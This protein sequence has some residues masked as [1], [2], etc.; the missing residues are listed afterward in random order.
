V[1]DLADLFKRGLREFD[2]RVRLVKEDQWNEST[3]CSEWDVRAL[4]NHIVYEDRWTPPILEGKTIEEVGDQFEGD[5]LGDD[6]VAAWD[7]ASREAAAAVERTSMDKI[8]HLSFGDVPA[9][10]YIDQLLN[11]HVIH[12]WDLARGIAADDSLDP[13]LVDYLYEKAKP[14]E[15]LLKGSGLFGEKIE[16]AEDADPQT[17][18]LAIMGR[19]P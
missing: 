7:E 14:Q 15:E 16:P 5:L 6:P 2:D 17:K 1:T 18:L 8:V 9:Q 4:V 10:L 13:E 11:D 19:R 3:P 12:G